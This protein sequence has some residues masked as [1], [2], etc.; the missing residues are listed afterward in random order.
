MRVMPLDW[1]FMKR[2]VRAVAMMQISVNMTRIS[3]K[4]KEQEAIY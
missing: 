3:G 4:H 1:K 2:I